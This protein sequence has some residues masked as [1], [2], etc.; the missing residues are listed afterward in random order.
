LAPGIVWNPLL[1]AAS[2]AI[3][4]GASAAALL[5][6]LWLR[7]IRAW[8]GLLCQALAALVLG[9]AICGMHC[10]GMAAANFPE[11]AV[12]LSAGALT[13]DRLGMLVSLSSVALLAMTLFTSILDARMQSS[14]NVPNIKSQAVNDELKNRALSWIV[15]RF[16]LPGLH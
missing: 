16:S 13:G 1:V 10:T 6:F 2:A 15:F 9:V 4:V 7:K 8:R 5:I 12:Y 14:L 3:A 11:G